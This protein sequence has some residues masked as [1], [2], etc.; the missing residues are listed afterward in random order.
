MDTVKR[1][2]LLAG[3]TD[4]SDGGTGRYLFNPTFHNSRKC[5]S[6]IMTEQC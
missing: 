3:E 4:V 5:F 6:L 2:G 1:D